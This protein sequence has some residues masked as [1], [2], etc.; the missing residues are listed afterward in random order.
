GTMSAYGLPA[1]CLVIP[2]LSMV[3]LW[4]SIRA[5]E[6]CWSMSSEFIQK[7]ENRVELVCCVLQCFAQREIE[8]SLALFARALF[9]KAVFNSNAALMFQIEKITDASSERRHETGMRQAAM[10]SRTGAREGGYT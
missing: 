8:P 5:G 3:F 10:V 2:V 7:A 9:A 1:S 4:Y 6:S